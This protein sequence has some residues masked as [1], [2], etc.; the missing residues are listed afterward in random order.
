VLLSTILDPSCTYSTLLCC[1][2]T[3]L[4]RDLPPKAP[5]PVEDEEEKV[6]EKEEP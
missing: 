4:P 1:P 5:S 2:L 6:E 3:N